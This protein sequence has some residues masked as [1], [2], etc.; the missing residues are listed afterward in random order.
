VKQKYKNRLVIM[1]RAI[2]LLTFA[3]VSLMSHALA[4]DAFGVRLMRPDSLAGWDHGLTPAGWTIAKGR[5]T[6]TADSAPLLSG[7]SFGDFE[8]R[9][10]WSVGRSGQWKVLFPEVPNGSGLTLL[11]CEGDS[12]ARLTD[13]EKELSP[14]GN[15]PP[16]GDH[17]HTATLRRSNGKVA[18]AV[19]GR[20]LG[21]VALPAQR[22]F[23][24][25]LAV[26]AGTA[27]MA[28]LCV[29]EPLGEPIFNGKDLSG[30]WTPGNIADWKVEANELVLQPG[31]GNYLRTERLFGN[32][33]LSLQ[34][35]AKKRCNSGIGLR[36]PRNGWPSSDGMELQLEDLPP[37]APLDKHSPMA[38]YGNVPPLARADRSEQWNDVVVK[39]DGWMIS[40]W[41]NGE[42]TQQANTFDHPELRHRHLKG[43]IG[44]QDHGSWVRFRN[45]RVLEAPDGLGLDAWRAPKPPRA[46]ALIIDR[47]MNPERLSVADGATSGTVIKTVSGDSKEETVLAQL[48]GPGAVVRVAQARPEGRLAF[49]FD[50]ERKPRI[51]CKAADLQK[52]VPVIC[53]DQQPVL[54]CVTYKKGLKITVREAN[55]TSVRLDYV[56]FP[57]DQQIASFVDRESGFLRGWLSAASYRHGQGAWGVHRE[58]DPYPRRSS[59]KKGLRPGANASLVSVEGAGIV[60]WIKLQADKKVLDNSDLWLEAAVDG[61]PAIAAPARFWF[62]SLAG[63]GNTDNFMMTDRGGP[64]VRLAMPYSREVRVSAVNRGSKPISDVGVTISYEPATDETRADFAQRMRLR[65]IYQGPG[66]DTMD[67][68]RVEGSGRWVGWVFE[69]APGQPVAVES[70][71]VDGQAVA[72]WEN[73]GMDLLLGRGGD[74]RSCLGG[75]FGGLAWEYLWLAPVEFRKSLAL[76]AN[77]N[78]LGGR[79]ALFYLSQRA[80]SATSRPSQP[81]GASDERR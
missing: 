31:N 1:R 61:E 59:P 78:K 75:R 26:G 32:F 21:E 3:T 38:I 6:G 48:A 42:L 41:V 17:M 51:D 69:Q 72:G 45:I 11:L 50:G 9:L 76:T 36:T 14:G 12:C 80:P 2:L 23:G 22:R 37:N 7:F 40:A 70:L 66:Q 43:W 60:H 35:K 71:T 15:V 68:V 49:Y 30:W 65:G 16:L 44:F 77:T 33:T 20:P 29:Q 19:D 73:V 24:L 13:G 39:A 25:A 10:R 5:L 54:T 46:T 28:D 81:R 8:L 27:E 47:L 74:F 4:E 57:Q 52:Y 55:P 34:F 64:M 53:D 79:L 63:Q 18:V 67:L 62:P 56:A 58:F